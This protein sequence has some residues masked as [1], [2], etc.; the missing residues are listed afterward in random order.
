MALNK[1]QTSLGVKIVLIML[2]VAFVASFIPLFGSVFSSG[3]DTT[4]QP[5]QL[6][7]LETIGQQFQPTVS[8]LTSQLQSDPE[9]YT[10]LVSL[11]NTYFDW[12]VQV[13]QAS[14]TDS[15]AIGADQPLWVAAKD[16]YRRALAVQAG[17]PPVAVDYAITLFYTGETN[18]A[19]KQAEQVTKDTPDFGPAYFNLGVF[20]NALSESAK[21]VA[22]YEQYLKLDPDGARGGDPAFAK[23][24]VERL[25]SATATGTP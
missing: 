10:V 5:G 9:S 19:V 15:A 23:S 4:N 22:A 1:A 24:E 2:I 18:E 17:E 3:T 14:Q 6:S 20:Y 12:A 21:A 7:T 8:G 13:Q 11:G 25:K 16:A